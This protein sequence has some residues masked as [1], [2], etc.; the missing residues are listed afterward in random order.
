M[1]LIDAVFIS[2]SV[3][4]KDEVTYIL[5]LAVVQIA[6]KESFHMHEIV[7]R[8]P[9]KFINISGSNNYTQ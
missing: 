2:Y 6:G 1:K 4:G 5:L 7:N 8:N 3:K 9:V